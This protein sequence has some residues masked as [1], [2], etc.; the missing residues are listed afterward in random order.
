ME[1]VGDS[2]EFVAQEVGGGKIIRGDDNL[3]EK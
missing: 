2:L 3:T 1:K